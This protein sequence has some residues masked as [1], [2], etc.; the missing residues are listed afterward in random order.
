MVCRYSP[1]L[2]LNSLDDFCP[3]RFPAGHLPDRLHRF[4]GLWH[5]LATVTD[6]CQAIHDRQVRHGHWH[7]DGQL[8]GDAVS[9]RA[10]VGSLVRPHRPPSRI[11]GRSGRF[12]PVLYDVRARNRLEKPD[13][14]IHFT[15]RAGIAGATIPT[16]QAYIADTTSLEARAKGMALIGAAFG[17]G[18][19]LGPL[20]GYLAL[21][22]GEG[23]PGPG[24]GFAAA[25]L[26]V[27]ALALAYFKLP[28]SLSSKSTSVA[29]KLFDYSS[30][31]D[32]LRIP[33]VGLLLLALFICILAF[34]NY[35]TTVAMLVKGEGFDSP[36]SFS[37]RQVCLTFAFIGLTLTLAQ[38]FFGPPLGRT[39]SRGS[40]GGDWRRF[41]YRRFPTH[42]CGNFGAVRQRIV[43]GDGSR[44]N[45]LLNDDAIAQFADFAP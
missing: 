39:N 22:S 41:R 9:V 2:I 31:R 45:R 19:T 7:A 26:S 21:P 24:P 20:F 28:E 27:G 10:D 12:G 8:F 5:G 40:I 13:W 17:A 32:A 18:F 38:G 1:I 43:C 16:T 30:L 34:A 6:L 35:E 15:D 37:F 29:R 23:D 4:I 11:N 42:E 33:S 14:F 36:F 25:V 44:C 3:P